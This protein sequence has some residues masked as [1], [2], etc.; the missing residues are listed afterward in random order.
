MPPV[1]LRRDQDC[2]VIFGPA[3][4]PLPQLKIT[5][6]AEGYLVAPQGF[7]RP[8]VRASGSVMHE[9]SS[10][11]RGAPTALRE[12]DE[13]SE[14]APGGGM[15]AAGGVAGWLDDRTGAAEAGRLPA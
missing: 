10:A 5:V 3:K 12:H 9:H 1:D 2:K 7:P 15:K 11:T 6:D 8:S 4:R 13:A 14:P